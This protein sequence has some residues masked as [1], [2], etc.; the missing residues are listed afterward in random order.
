MAMRYRLQWINR[1]QAQ[2][3]RKRDDHQFIS[4]GGFKEW[5]LVQ[6]PSRPLPYG[7]R[8]PLM[9]SNK[10]CITAAKTGFLLLQTLYGR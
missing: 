10:N 2:D 6:W 1:L 7:P 8:R 9:K 3:L 4:R 5:P